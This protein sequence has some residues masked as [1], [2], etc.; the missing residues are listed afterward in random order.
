M[1][2]VTYNPSKYKPFARGK[3]HLLEDSFICSHC[4]AI[5][6]TQPMISGVQNRNHC[7][8][9]LSSRH[10]DHAQ[11]GDRLSACR[12]IMQPVGLTVKPSRNK[13]GKNISG[14][15]ML[16][17]RCRD[18]GKLSINRLAADDQVDRLMEIFISSVD[19]EVHL[20]HQLS[21]NGI[22]MLTQDDFTL[23]E[24]QLIGCISK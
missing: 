24:C 22:H 6:Y 3:N 10:V 23:V 19:T 21:E 5:I 15:L 17:H 7:P 20:L 18:C 12:G 1:C 4:G 14:E 9:C 11:A 8:Y 16:I 2:P 13:Y